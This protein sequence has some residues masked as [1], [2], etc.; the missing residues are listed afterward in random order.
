MLAR[1]AGRSML[2]GMA[3]GLIC[4]VLKSFRY[5]SGLTGF[6]NVVSGTIQR[7]VQKLGRDVSLDLAVRHRATGYSKCSLL[8]RGVCI[9]SYRL[10]PDFIPVLGCS[11]PDL[12]AAG[13]WLAIRLSP[14]T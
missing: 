10:D 4:S 7:A 11:L 5:S 6:S 8:D 2:Y 12:A 1:G 3:P 9:Q 14:R 13:H